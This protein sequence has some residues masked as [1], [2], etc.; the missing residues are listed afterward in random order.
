MNAKDL[1]FITLWIIISIILYAFCLDQEWEI[2]TD[3]FKN[4]MDC[5]KVQNKN[6]KSDQKTENMPISIKLAQ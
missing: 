3:D 1:T 5:K 6:V 4:E 2:E